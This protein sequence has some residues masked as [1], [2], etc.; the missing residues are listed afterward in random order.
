MGATQVV[1]PQC[2]KCGRFCECQKHGLL[3]GL[4]ALGKKQ[5]ASLPLHSSCNTCVVN[6]LFKVTQKNLVCRY[7]DGFIGDLCYKI[8]QVD[9]FSLGNY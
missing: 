6:T 9:V 8:I 5:L 1:R 3:E 2:G 7:Y 4:F